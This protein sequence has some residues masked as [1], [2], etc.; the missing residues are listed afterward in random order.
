MCVRLNQESLKKLPN[1]TK[2]K[3]S[4]CIVKIPKISCKKV[5]NGSKCKAISGSSVNPKRKKATF[6]MKRYRR[7]NIFKT[8]LNKNDLENF[9][10]SKVFKNSFFYK[11]HLQWNNL[12]LEL[13]IIED[14]EKF[15]IM[16]KEHIWDS[17]EP[18]LN[19]ENDLG[20]PDTSIT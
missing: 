7:E 8:D 13:R 18:H 20:C 14:Y 5:G 15:S 6:K 11:T 2:N 17:I 9:T 1:T 16:L 3:G 12:P 4:K 10:E 19:K